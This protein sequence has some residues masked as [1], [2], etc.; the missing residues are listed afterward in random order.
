[1]TWLLMFVVMYLHPT[2]TSQAAEPAANLFTVPLFS[3]HANNRLANKEILK[4]AQDERGFVWL[5]TAR[6]LFRFDGYEYKK[7]MG[8][9]HGNEIG[10]IYVR[11]LLTQGDTLWIGTMSSGLYRLDLVSGD[12]R[13]Y[14]HQSDN[15]N[16]LGGNQVNA[17]EQGDK[18]E[19]WIAH[20]F[21]LDSFDPQR[22]EFKHYFS[23][24]NP[25]DRYFNYLLDMEFDANQRLWLST[26]KG[27]ATFNLATN[28]F[29]LF[30]PHEPQSLLNTV[31]TRKIFRASDGRLWLATQKQGIYIVDPADFGVT[32]LSDAPGREN[33]LNTTLAETQDPI[34][35][36]RH[37]WVAGYEGVEMRDA[38][39]GQLLKVLKGN[40]S[41]PYGLQGD[42]VYPL[43]TLSSGMLFMGVNN[44]GL[45]FYNPLTSQY[46]Y[47]DKFS[48]QLESTFASVLHQ[49]IRLDTSDIVLFSQQAMVR[50]DLSSGAVRPF[51]PYP[52]LRGREVVSGLRDADGIYWLGG[53]NG[54]IFR[55]DEQQQSVQELRLPLPKNEGVFVRHLAQSHSGDLWIGSDRGLVKLNPA[56]LAFSQVQ[57]LDGSPYINYVRTLLVD[58]RDRL[59]IG[60]NSGFGVITPDTHSVR[61]YSSQQG[62]K[63]TLSH[64]SIVQIY[65]NQQQQIM[66]VTRA[67][68]DRLIDDSTEIKE[69]APFAA[70]VTRQLD[71]EEHIIQLQNGDY[72]IGTRYLVN[73]AG[74]LLAKFDE[75]QGALAKGRSRASLLLDSGH[76]L[77][78]YNG[79]LVRFAQH[80]Q[81]HRQSPGSLVITDATV[82]NNSLMLDYRAP[83]IRVANTDQQF[84]LRFAAL[85]YAQ[86]DLQYR[87]LLRGYDDD[88]HSS[89]ADIRQ[90]TYTALSPGQYQLEVQASDSDGQWQT[91]AVRVSVRVEPKYYQTLWFQLLALLLGSLVFYGVFRWRL[92][93]AQHQQRE[94]Y[95]KREAL[96]KAQMMTELM[97]QKNKMLAEVTH[98]LRTPLAMV[99]MQLEAMQDGV[100]QS[101][102][103]SYD[104]LQQ[105]ITTLNNMVGDIYQLSLAE[106]GALRLNRQALD[107]A[108][109][110][111]TA[112]DSFATLMQQKQ[113]QLYFQDNSDGKAW[114]LADEGRI[115]QVLT[116]LLKNS[117][118]Y[119]YDSGRVEVSLTVVGANAVLNIADSA[120]AVSEVELNRLFERLYRAQ[121]TRGQSQTGSGL[122][123]W[124]CRSIVEAHQGEISAGLS[125]Q[126]GLLINIVLPLVDM[127]LECEE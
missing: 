36:Q 26:A 24:D 76:I 93:I 127:R 43:L 86:P 79:G 125:V 115:N 73:E 90:A 105:R 124:I 51:L 3:V 101:D 30:Q 20:S 122:G 27:L 41:D 8:D 65:Q 88:W 29:S 34:S 95:E 112:V 119:T 39:S 87:Y 61:F 22:N 94:R 69:F 72:W 99:K 11:S 54:N 108:V 42:N 82:G 63:G 60:S 35:G 92:A 55:V 68:I 7:I 71:T 84:S 16:S 102:E 47:F 85:N 59:W 18:G 38:D 52:A 109:L 49:V 107:V 106:G 44:V 58:A 96:Q 97:E 66:L 113:L 126:G 28:D 15:N 57:N 45:Q 46:Q 123:L 77:H 81:K 70:E 25:A 33:T 19:L 56:T 9:R 1:M 17:I 118:R 2:W 117:Y 91:D 75:S 40:L 100:L 116:N 89:P 103:K 111:Q 48:P 23:A 31:V 14:L 64:D 120:P 50:V 53:G 6:G 121:S 37:I 83:T 78:F 80:I 12:I 10:N 74:D 32:R 104:T 67:G 62:T 114:V 4:L 5:G 98:D 110:T 21:G 13:Q